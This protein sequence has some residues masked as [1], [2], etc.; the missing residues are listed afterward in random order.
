[1][2]S[3]SVDTEVSKRLAHRRVSL[4]A[5][6]AGGASVLAAL[7]SRLENVALTLHSSGPAG[8]VFGNSGLAEC[9]HDC[10]CSPDV[11]LTATSWKSR[12]ETN[13]WRMARARG[14][15]TYV[16]LDHWSNYAQRFIRDGVQVMPDELWVT[17][18]WAYELALQECPNVPLRLVPA[19]YRED[20]ALSIRSARVA[21]R[22]LQA[23]SEELRVL[24]L[25]ETLQAVEHEKTY[26]IAQVFPD[27]LDMVRV[28]LEAIRLVPGDVRLRIRPHPT[29]GTGFYESAASNADE[30]HIEFSRRGATLVEDLA[31]ADLCVGASTMAM[32]HALDGGV[33][34]VQAFPRSK[35]R[36]PLPMAFPVLEGLD[37]E[38]LLGFRR[39]SGA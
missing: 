1:M 32:V 14:I 8:R 24:L 4:Y 37:Q 13:A 29:Q 20:F 2:M 19:H 38:S 11:V 36:S 33:P 17:D 23:P 7:A 12:H 6:D 35:I 9:L 3:C 21:R 26:Q 30:V 22:S 16:V 39:R 18:P 25:G 34:V 31:W 27:E 5:H 28:T 15:A 10:T